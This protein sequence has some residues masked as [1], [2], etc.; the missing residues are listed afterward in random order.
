MVNKVM[1][2]GNSGKDPEVKHLPDGRVVA[3]FSLAT[4]ETWKDKSGEKKEETQWHTVTFW[5][6]LAEVIEKYV[7]KGDPL[8]V[9]GSIKYRSYEKDG[10]TKYFTEISG[11]SLRLLKK[12]E[13]GELAPQAFNSTA[14]AKQNPV[15]DQS[16]EDDLPF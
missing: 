10:S 7:K 12:K 11:E 13:D 3:R 15:A 16:E 2:I 8:F 14:G 9:E 1:L 5:G 6:K 4:S